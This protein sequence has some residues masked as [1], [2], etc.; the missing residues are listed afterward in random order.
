MERHRANGE[1]VEGVKKV[2]K[3]VSLFMVSQETA[4]NCHISD[5]GSE[6]GDHK[7]AKG[8]RCSI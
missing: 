1:M 8:E 7:S 3:Q 5:E 4:L 2:E 6:H